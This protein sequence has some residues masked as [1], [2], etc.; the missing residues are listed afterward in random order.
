L[1][2]SF[3]FDGNCV[4]EPPLP[5]GNT[6]FQFGRNHKFLIGRLVLDAK[7]IG[8]AADLTVFDIRLPAASGLIHRRLVALAASGTLKSGPHLNHS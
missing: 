2:S 5:S 3:L 1:R 4:T 6:L 8:F 7:Q